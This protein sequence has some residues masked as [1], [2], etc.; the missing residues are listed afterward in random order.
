MR[1][2]SRQ[3]LPEDSDLAAFE[4]N[5]REQDNL[6][7]GRLADSENAV[8]I[9]ATLLDIR[10][11]LRDWRT[12]SAAE[13]EQRKTLSKWGKTCEQNLTLL[14]NEQQVWET[15]LRT[16]TR[17]PEL[18]S[19]VVRVRSTITDIQAVHG[20][21]E[22]RLRTVLDLQARMSKQALIVADMVEKLEA[23]RQ[24]FQARIFYPDA[25][26][27]WQALPKDG[28]EPISTVLSRSIAKFYSDSV[29]FAKVHRGGLF[30]GVLFIV[31]AV[32]I[33]RRLRHVF[34]N[35]GSQDETV[36][37]AALVLKR[38]VS[39]AAIIAAPLITLSSPN[40]RTNVVLL[41][42]S[43]F[44]L[45][46]TRLLPLYTPAVRLVYF[47]AGFYG[48]NICVGT[49]DADPV[50]RRWL[51][52]LIFATAACILAWWGRPERL[53]RADLREGSLPKMVFLL[54][55]GVLHW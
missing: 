25:P 24:G 23:V 27:I 47:M 39:L 35:I 7:R 3:A 12:Y 37:R 53:H 55:V 54:F 32:V 26:P 28:T 31:F 11:L 1:D 30:R 48:L 43:I 19:L 13:S 14:N 15:T 38:P 6:V 45:P 46:I 40:A 44:L 5:L 18:S 4:N 52:A 36:A 22:Q 29:S 8:A 50:V 2:I 51:I 33:S 9:G 17:V 16:I 20:A 10:G 34:L 41:L 21:A 49:L 42:I